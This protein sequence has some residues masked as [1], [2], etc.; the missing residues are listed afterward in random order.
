MLA[1]SRSG[2]RF[3]LQ[4]ATCSLTR[5]LGYLRS[6]SFLTGKAKRPFHEFAIKG[7]LFTPQNVKESH[8]PDRLPLLIVDFCLR[9]ISKMSTGRLNTATARGP[10]HHF[11]IGPF[12]VSY[13]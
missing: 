10:T 9:S 5:Y 6:A 13:P 3:W 1:S 12:H 4:E 8:H 2:A 7:I 11:R